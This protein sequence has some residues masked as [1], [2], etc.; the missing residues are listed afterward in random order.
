MIRRVKPA[1]AAAICDIYNYYVENT[2]ISFE[3]KPVS[4]N[5]ME[6]RIRNISSKYP[7]LIREEE[8]GEINGF[9]YACPWKDRSAYRFSAELSVYVRKGFLGRGIGWELMERILEEA[10]TTDLHS[11]VSGI[12]LPNER[13]IALHEKAGFR[14]IAQ[15][16]EIGFKF[17]KWHDVGY[18]E[19]VLK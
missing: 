12:A 8:D 5:E 16:D 9:V 18:W 11:L 1:D 10:R 13:S 15:F 17:N 14:K 3:E 2:M 7:Y 19:L 4:K 6:S